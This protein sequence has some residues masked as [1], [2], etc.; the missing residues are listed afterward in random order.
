MRPT[1]GSSVPQGAAGHATE[2]LAAASLRDRRRRTFFAVELLIHPAFAGAAESEAGVELNE[3][4][5]RILKALQATPKGAQ[6]LV[7]ALG[8]RSA[9]GSLWKAL[10]RLDDLV[11]IGLTLPSKSKSGKQK[12]RLT[13]RGQEVL[14][15]LEEEGR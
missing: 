12:R 15:R 11:F 4:E 10:Q 6:G 1:I 5:L 3:T 8:L 13:P 2:R 9:S 14:R 7:T